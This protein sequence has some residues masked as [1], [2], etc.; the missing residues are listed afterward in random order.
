MGEQKDPKMAAAKY[1][2]EIG[3][4]VTTAVAAARDKISKAV[5]ER[6]VDGIVLNALIDAMANSMAIYL[7]IVHDIPP[8]SEEFEKLSAKIMRDT[9]FAMK[10]V[11]AKNSDS[12]VTIELSSHREGNAE[13]GPEKTV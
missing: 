9:H 6:L 4:E 13:E 12:G 10:D 1:A 2:A 8:G 7:S 3:M 11:M 5:D